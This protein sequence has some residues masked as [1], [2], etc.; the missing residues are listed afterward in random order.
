MQYPPNCTLVPFDWLTVGGAPKGLFCRAGVPQCLLA[1]SALANGGRAAVTVRR[2]KAA[3][4]SRPL[5]PAVM[6]SP[7]HS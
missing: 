2:S 4:S 5:A 3:C 7:P 1:K 6:G